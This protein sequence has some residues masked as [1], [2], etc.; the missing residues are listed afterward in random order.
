M[1]TDLATFDVTYRKLR[2]KFE[3]SRQ[4][5]NSSETLKF[6]YSSQLSGR[7]IRIIELLPGEP[8]DQLA[9]NVAEASLDDPP[10]YEA[11]S[12]VWGDPSVKEPVQCN[13]CVVF[14]TVSLTQALR[15]IR[16][17]KASRLV[18]ADAIALNQDDETEKNHQVRLM[19]EVY[20]RA[21]K[22]IIWL[23]PDDDQDVAVACA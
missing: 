7:N 17:P 15:R 10:S 23:G 16:H 11:I 14:V 20:S 3:S 13:G 19:G 22:V 6:I 1:N 4:R 2:K 12:Y 8:G 21:A 9:C 18:W 5:A